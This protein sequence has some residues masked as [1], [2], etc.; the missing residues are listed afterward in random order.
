MAAGGVLGFGGTRVSW[1][2]AR[3]EEGGG[4]GGGG[5]AP[6]AGGPASAADPVPGRQEPDRAH[7]GGSRPEEEEEHPAPVRRPWRHGE[8][9]ERKATGGPVKVQEVAASSCSA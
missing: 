9:A 8:E 4:G 7:G 1:E 2:V 3:P 6:G 5:V